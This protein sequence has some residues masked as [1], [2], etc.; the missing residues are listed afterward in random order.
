MSYHFATNRFAHARPEAIITLL[1]PVPSPAVQTRTT[2]FDSPSHFASSTAGP[3]HLVDTHLLVRDSG[4]GQLKKPWGRLGSCISNRQS[5]T[6]A[7]KSANKVSAS[8][9]QQQP[10]ALEH[11][12]QSSGSS[13]HTYATRISTRQHRIEAESSI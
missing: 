6:V 1:V 8:N 2:S 9:H 13:L 4:D 7:A 3:R 10:E 12:Q 5:R 11:C